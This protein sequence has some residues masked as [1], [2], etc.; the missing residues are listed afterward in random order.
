MSKRFKLVK[1]YYYLGLWD[2]RRVHA[3]VGKWIT[4]AEYKTITGDDYNAQ[5]SD[6]HSR[7]A[8]ADAYG[9]RK[10]NHA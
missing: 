6:N 3:A 7:P 4:A 1:H 9:K 2:K 8:D 5:I 10:D